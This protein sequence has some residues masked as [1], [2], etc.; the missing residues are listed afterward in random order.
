MLRIMCQNGA[1]HERCSLVRD[2]DAPGQFTDLD[3]LDH[4]KRSDV[5]DGYIIRYAV[6]A[7]QVLL[8]RRERHVPDALTDKQ[9]FRD[10]MRDAIDHRDAVCRPQRDE[11][12]LAV[13]RQIDTDR[14]DRPATQAWN[15]ERDLLLHLAFDRIDHA[16]GSADLR[17]YPKLRTV[18][19]KLGVARARIDEDVGDDLPRGRIDEMRHVRRFRRVDQDLA[20]RAHAHAFRLD[21]DLHVAEAPAPLDVDDRHRIVVLVGD[22]ECLAGRVLDE[23]LRVGTGR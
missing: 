18:A 15:L 23:Q 12:G 16:D 2:G 17:R 9:I 5:D 14:L 11:A 3:G 7:Q 19:L 21:A 22:V 8:V 6:R 10:L 13:F 1:G 4:P 20:V